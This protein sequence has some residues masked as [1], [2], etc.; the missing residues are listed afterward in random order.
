MCFIHCFGKESTSNAGG[1]S[2]ISG[3]GRSQPR[4]RDRLPTPILL[5]FSGDSDSKESACKA[6]DLVSIPGLGRP[7]RNIFW[8]KSW[9]PTPVFLP[10]KSLWIEVPGGLQSTG[11][12]RVGQDWVTEAQHSTYISDLFLSKVKVKVAQSCP[13]HCDPTD[14]TVHDSLGQNTGVGSRSLD[15]CLSHEGNPK[16]YRGTFDLALRSFSGELLN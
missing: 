2:S 8:R 1:S 7:R 4:R 14:Y 13:T 5:G 3:L 16:I 10:G 6:G 11:S 15:H 9:Q 12:Q